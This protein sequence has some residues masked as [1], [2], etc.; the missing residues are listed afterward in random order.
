MDAGVH[1]FLVGRPRRF[2]ETLTS[3][4]LPSK[5]S[6]NTTSLQRRKE[7]TVLNVM[8]STKP[9]SSDWLTMHDHEIINYGFWK[10]SKC[11]YVTLRFMLP[12]YS[13]QQSCKQ[14]SNLSQN[15]CFYIQQAKFYRFAAQSVIT[16]VEGFHF[17]FSRSS[18]LRKFNAYTNKV[19]KSFNNFS[20]LYYRLP[21][22]LCQHRN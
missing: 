22:C 12:V 11:T 10:Q 16:N 19:S 18:A 2:W 6:P 7:A 8:N 14:D 1:N 17:R 3:I 13:M 4:L 21:K 5:Q 15:R 9:G 20:L